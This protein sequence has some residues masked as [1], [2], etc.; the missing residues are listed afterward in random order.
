MQRVITHRLAGLGMAAVLTLMAAGGAVA[1]YAAGGPGESMSPVG[2]ADRLVR[3]TQSNSSV[4]W[5]SMAGNVSTIETL[6]W[7]SSDGTH[8]LGG[9]LMIEAPRNPTAGAINIGEK[10]MSVAFS[11]GD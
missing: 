6:G 1:V 8:D 2:G 9:A 10:P 4:L 11:L 5:T 3:L 7:P